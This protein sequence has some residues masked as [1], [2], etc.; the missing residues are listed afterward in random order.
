MKGSI[1]W[2]NGRM[3]IDDKL[4]FKSATRCHYRKAT[5]LITG[6]DAI[7]RPLAMR[8]GMVSRFAWMKF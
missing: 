1:Q 6:F 2:R 3:R 7:G 8:V 5:R 4:T